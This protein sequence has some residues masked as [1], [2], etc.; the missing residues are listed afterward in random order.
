MGTS[1][2]DASPRNRGRGGGNDDDDDDDDDDTPEPTHRGET[3]TGPPELVNPAPI[4][5]LTVRLAGMRSSALAP[6]PGPNI[7]VL[8]K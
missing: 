8:G 2:R 5:R 3:F 7:M 1:P 4:P 6:R